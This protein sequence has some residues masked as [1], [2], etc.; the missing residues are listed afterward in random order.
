MD[1]IRKAL[2]CFSIL[3]ILVLAC[4][5]VNTPEKIDIN[6]NSNTN[7]GENTEKPINQEN[8]NVNNVENKKESQSTQNI[9][10][11]EN[12]EIK[13]QENHPLQS[14]QNYEQT[15][16]N[17]NEENENA[18]TNVGES[19]V[20]YNNEPAYNYYIEITYPDG[21]I[22]DKIEE[23]MLYYIKVI[24][25][26]VGG[27]A[28]I[29]IYVDGN[30]I[31]TLDD[32]YGIVECV[33]YEP[34]YHTI[35]AE[36]NGKILASK[37]VYVEEGTAYNSGE[38]ENYDEYDNNYESNDLQQTQTQFSEIEVYVDDIKPSNSIIITKL[39]MN[40]GFLASINGISPDIG[41][42]IEM[43]NGE[44]INLKYVSMDVD[45]IIDNPN[46][47][48]ITIDK[49]ILNMFD[50]EGHSLGRGEVSNIVITPG[51]NPVTVKVNIPINKMGYEILR[52]LSGEE[53]F[54]EISGSAYIE[55]SGE[56]PFSGEAD[57][58]PPL[59]TPPFPLPPLPPFPTE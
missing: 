17:F 57:L 21:T 56:V 7:N 24:D 40:P 44:K 15:N 46:S 48:S 49:I 31:G 8:Q 26:I 20:N 27:L 10:S 58:L 51:E 5:C 32:V 1:T 2:V 16:G 22:P 18:M 42:N 12:K 19:E 29:D 45:L 11:Y 53:V 13:N 14:N 36:D 39:A 6:I 55:G 41:V 28:G 50:D 30:Y 47:E 38:S 37:T 59:P 54:A 33:F 43:E 35:T 52:K 34:G 3:S 23:Q 4:G 9:Q 25:P